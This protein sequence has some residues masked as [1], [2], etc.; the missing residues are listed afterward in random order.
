MMNSIHDRYTESY[1]LSDMIL[2]YLKAHP[3]AGDTL[4]GVVNW[5]LDYEHVTYVI[6]EIHQ[7]LDKLVAEGQV[8]VVKGLSEEAF[9]KAT[10][11]SK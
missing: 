6:K 4:E 2:S 3:N 9:Y 7:T 1:N 10:P 8:K 5:W 11:H